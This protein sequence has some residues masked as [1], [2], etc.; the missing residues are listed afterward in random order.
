MVV[1]WID[2]DSNWNPWRAHTGNGGNCTLLDLP[3]NEV[4]LIVSAPGYLAKVVRMIDV[5]PQPGAVSLAAGALGPPTQH[6]I[7]RKRTLRA[8]SQDSH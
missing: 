3:F 7:R 6:T 1:P 8:A 2:P 4:P 5:A